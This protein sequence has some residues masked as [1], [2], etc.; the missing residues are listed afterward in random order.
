MKK[1]KVDLAALEGG[2]AAA[3]TAVSEDFPDMFEEQRR[4]FGKMAMGKL[5]LVT[6]SSHR[7]FRC[8]GKGDTIEAQVEFHYCQEHYKELLGSLENLPTLISAE[9]ANDAAQE[10]TEAAMGIA[11]YPVLIGEK[12]LSE[13]TLPRCE[14]LDATAQAWLA[15]VADFSSEVSK[16]AEQIRGRLIRRG[17]L[18]ISERE[19]GDRLLAITDGIQKYFDRYDSSYPK[20]LNASNR[21]FQGYHA[22]ERMVGGAS[23]WA[24]KMLNDIDDPL[25]NSSII[26]DGD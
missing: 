25:T 3:L 13:I 19:L 10:V 2:V 11:F 21:R 15:G 6:R 14:D 24:L 20:I 18:E 1:T 8:L 16:L 7:V 23:Q 4:A 17:E 5:R 12:E 26:A 22:K 9:I